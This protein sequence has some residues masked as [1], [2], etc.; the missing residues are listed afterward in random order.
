V[1]DTFPRK[2][3]ETIRSWMRCA[4]PDRIRSRPHIDVLLEVG[5]RSLEGVGI[6][7]VKLV[8]TIM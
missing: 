5:R 4:T 1:I 3:R 2:A 7:R 6:G 8:E